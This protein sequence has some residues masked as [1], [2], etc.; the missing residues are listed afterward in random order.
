MGVS[1]LYRLFGEE[2]GMMDLLSSV[3]PASKNILVQMLQNRFNTPLTSSCGRLFDGFA[4]LL[5]LNTVSTFEGQAAMQL[6][7]L[8]R[9]SLTT[10]W[11]DILVEEIEGVEHYLKQEKEQRWEINSSKFVKKALDDISSGMDRSVIALQFHSWLISCI[12]R[13]VEKLSGT[14]GIRDVVLSGGSMQN[15]I[16]LEG[17]LFS[18]TEL[19]L[20]P[21]TGAR[22]PINDGGVSI[23]QALIGG[24][25]HVSRSTNES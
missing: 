5:G 9:G 12:S 18:L 19:G 14:T 8:A 24:M 11:K 25:Q 22:I 20:N 23:G 13:L 4:A 17:L 2:C 16:L 7:A 10:R 15:G 21:Y 6:E 3:D 1:L